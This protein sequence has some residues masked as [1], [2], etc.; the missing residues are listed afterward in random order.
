MLVTILS[1]CEERPPSN[2]PPE[3]GSPELTGTVWVLES[4]VQ[5]KSVS[6]V[7]GER[8]TLELFNDGSMLGSTGCRALTGRYTIAGVEVTMAELSTHGEC[9]IELRGQDSAV[10]RVLD[11]GFRVEV[12]DEILTVTSTGSEGLA[13]RAEP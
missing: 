11:D 10:V 6:D 12:D 3:A 4:L 1:T 7:G 13:Y 2:E 5:G 9:P 8:A